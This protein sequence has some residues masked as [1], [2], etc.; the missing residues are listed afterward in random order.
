MQ[1]IK[2]KFDEIVFDELIFDKVSFD[3]RA[4]D[5]SMIKFDGMT[6]RLKFYH[7]KK[8]IVDVVITWGAILLNRLVKLGKKRFQY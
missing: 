1:K 6:P 7:H 3:E 2:L 4:F 8:S 5:D